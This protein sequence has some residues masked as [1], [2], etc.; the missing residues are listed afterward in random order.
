MNNLNEK[1]LI[2]FFPLFVNLAET[3]RALAIA[4]RYVE[5][6]G[7]AIFIS[8]GGKYEYLA[9]DL[10]FKIIRVNPIHSDDFVDR[11]WKRSG[12]G[13]SK[14]PLTN[15]VLVEHVEEEFSA[16]RNTGVKLIVSTN[17]LAC[18]ISARVA[19]IPLIN[20]TP[21]VILHFNQYPDKAEF[22]FTRF[23]PE[24]LK[25]KVFNWYVSAT[26]GKMNIKTILETAKKYN[27]SDIK[28]EIDIFRGDYTFYT[29]F[30][31]FLGMDKSDIL[32][33]E[34]Y[35]GIIF[36][37]EILARYNKE[38]IDDQK[39][40][41]EHLKKPGRSILLT[42]GSSGTKDIFLKILNSLNETGYNV[43]AIHASILEEKDLPKLNDNMLIKKFV[44]SIRKLHRKV[45]LS[46][47]HG[48]QGTVYSA[49]YAGK[50]VI[51]Y[52]MQSEQH[53]NLEQLVK[54][55]TAFIKSVR[56]FNEKSLLKS[57]EDIFD[58][59]DYFLENA[60][61]LAKKLPDSNGVEKS[62]KLILKIL[63]KEGLT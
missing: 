55:G 40:I 27:V 32:P 15:K 50:P 31:D 19:G 37:D 18:G 26:E 28:R 20:I 61:N 2:G 33:N 59:Y 4:K 3:G 51:G 57:V 14:N 53:L 62:I 42:L 17:S 5:I 63:E 54:R 21:K 39:E 58:N 52:P 9:K 38:Q 56:Y 34:Y 43:I 16:Y 29:N 44:P 45:D 13:I 6:G 22:L 10:G 8:H 25:L 60:Q 35:V 46:I 1:P 36:F 23:I 12:F 41:E 24:R 48:G 47:I 11:A 30:V 7:K 49:A